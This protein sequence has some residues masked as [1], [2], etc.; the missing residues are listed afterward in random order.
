MYQLP[1]DHALPDQGQ[2]CAVLV[3]LSSSS[4][5]LLVALLIL[6]LGAEGLGLGLP[7]TFLA[8]P[9]EQEKLRGSWARMF[10]TDSI[11]QIPSDMSTFN[12]IIM[13]GA[14]AIGWPCVPCIL[15]GRA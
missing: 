6:G 5:S 11:L 13:A 4:D 2:Q 7:S 14:S 12:V 1:H 8:D 9:S 3:S 15:A 10:S